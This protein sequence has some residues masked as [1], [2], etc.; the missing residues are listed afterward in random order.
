MKISIKQ[1]QRLNEYQKVQLLWFQGVPME[2]VRFT[3]DMRVEL[4]AMD[5]FY[6]EVYYDASQEE[7]LFVKAFSN[8]KKL[9]PYLSQVD[10][11]GIM[12]LR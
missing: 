10:I 6:A 5:R 11:S 1:Y 7:P 2:V 9:D 8:M 12:Q 3:K 4:Y